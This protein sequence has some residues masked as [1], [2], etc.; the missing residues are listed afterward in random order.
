[1]KQNSAPPSFSKTLRRWLRRSPLPLFLALIGVIYLLS[2][3]FGLSRAEPM[4]TE[5]DSRLA[6]VGAASS[7]ETMQTSST[8]APQ[9]TTTEAPQTTETPT[10][11]APQTTETPTTEAPQTT[12]TPTT[13]AP[14]TTETPTT[15]A[16]ATTEAKEEGRTIYLTFDDGPGKNTEKVLDIL[17]RYGVRATFFTVGFY[18]DRY[19]EIAAKITKQGSL[20][21]CHSYTHEYDQCYASVDAFFQEMEKWKTAVKNACGTVPERICVRFPGG[22]TTPNAKNVSAGIKE[23]LARE[24][25]HWFDWNAA[26]NDKYPKGNVKNLPDA[27]YFWASYQ[28]TIGWYANKPNAQVVF[29][30]HDSENGTVEI[31]PRMIED[32]LAKGY[33]FKTLD[34]H[35]EWG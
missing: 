31:L 8:Q 33:T 23:R 14:Q 4:E 13:E 28:E 20:I 24:G 9:I 15:E 22:S 3:S 29:L 5:P 30:T 1:M 16:P 6:S 35:P 18:V 17:D 10:T 26:D 32:L 2:G 27:E 19:P 11:A 7:T 12:E 34:Q 25:Y 21:A